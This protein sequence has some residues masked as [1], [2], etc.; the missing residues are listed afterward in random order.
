MKKDRETRNRKILAYLG[1]TLRIIVG[2][3]VIAASVV[4]FLEM[5]DYAATRTVYILCFLAPVSA[6]A[7][8]GGD[9]Y[10]RYKLDIR[11]LRN[12]KKDQD[13]NP[14]EFK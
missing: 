3:M 1:F 6:V 12:K 7:L 5:A 10:I 13:R 14:L 11:P 4:F 8:V 2:V 9:L